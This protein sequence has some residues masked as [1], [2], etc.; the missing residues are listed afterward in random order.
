MDQGIM[1]KIPKM[2]QSELAD[3][4]AGLNEKEVPALVEAL[5]SQ[6]DEVR[7]PAFLLLRA[8]SGMRGD[9][10]PYW[11]T[12][13]EKL[14]SGN[15]YQRTIG[16]V[17]LAENAK[18]DTQNKLDG[19][20]DLYLSFCGDEKAATA[21]QC[22]QSIARILPVKRRLHG[23]IADRL[24]SVNISERKET[25]QKLVLKDILGILLQIRN[26]GPNERIDRYIENARTSLDKKTKKELFG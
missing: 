16:L 26:D 19:I 10:Y 18:W 2:D 13:L 5:A 12:F 1:D 11:E 15:S 22:I 6:K 7:Y 21:R 9:L 14:K 23:I 17:M 25:Q 24:M 20:I 3:L 8:L 4:A